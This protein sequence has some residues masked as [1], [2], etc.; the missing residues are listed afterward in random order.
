[1]RN[2][3]TISQEGRNFL[4]RIGWMVL[5]VKSLVNL[6][7]FFISFEDHESRWMDRWMDGIGS[8]KPCQS[9]LVF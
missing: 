5:G 3:F 6:F 1:L 7:G 9:F 2:I 4:M 8:E